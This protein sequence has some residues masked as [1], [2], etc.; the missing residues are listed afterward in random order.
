MWFP[1]IAVVDDQFGCGDGIG[2]RPGE[3]VAVMGPVEEQGR[4]VEQGPTEAVLAAPQADYT[5]MLLDA[6]PDISRVA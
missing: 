3:I 4:I 5:R 6:V 2:E 1:D